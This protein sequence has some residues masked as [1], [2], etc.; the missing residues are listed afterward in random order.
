MGTL[1]LRTPVLIQYWTHLFIHKYIPCH[2]YNATLWWCITKQYASWCCYGHQNSTATA[3]DGDHQT[4]FSEVILVAVSLKIRPIWESIS[5]GQH[6]AMCIPL[7]RRQRHRNSTATAV[8]GDH[9]TVSSEVFLVGVSWKIWP[10]WESTPGQ[11]PATC[12]P[13][14]R[15]GR[16]VKPCSYCKP[17]P[18]WWQIKK[19][20]ATDRVSKSWHH[21]NIN[22]YVYPS[23]KQRSNCKSPITLL[24]YHLVLFSALLLI[25]FVI[26]TYHLLFCN[27]STY[28]SQVGSKMVL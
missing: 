15:R 8:D 23:V 4:V 16:H 24:I 28:D 26:H 13:L 18:L 21:D 27:I 19:T 17:P 11:H 14:L 9:Q 5:I 2:I 3:V 22:A 1:Y 7:L 20:A 25:P 10:I 6:P 12:I